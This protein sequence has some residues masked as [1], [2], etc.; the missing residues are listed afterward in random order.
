MRLF[1]LGFVIYCTAISS[2]SAV[3]VSGSASDDSATV[4]GGGFGSTPASDYLGVVTNLSPLQINGDSQTVSSSFSPVVGD[5]IGRDLASTG[6]NF[7][8]DTITWTVSLPGVG[9]DFVPGTFDV[10]ANFSTSLDF[11]G[12]AFSGTQ[13]NALNFDLSFDGSSQDVFQA[14][15]GIH[16][17]ATLSVTSFG[18]APVTEVVVSAGFPAGNSFDAGSEQF[19]IFSDS[20][21]VTYSFETAAVPEPSAFLFGGLVCG[22]LGVT[23]FRKRKTAEV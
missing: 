6:I 16:T 14:Q 15:S 12:N 5:V 2:A 18:G 3:L 4:N 7:T 23:N 9:G 22:V 19:R 13:P 1:T 17:S 21:S 11:D 10:T 20:L 8:G